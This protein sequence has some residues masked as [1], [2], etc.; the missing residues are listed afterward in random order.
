MS[1]NVRRPISQ[2]CLR[3]LPK[4]GEIKNSLH[5][6]LL[7]CSECDEEV[8]I[9]TDIIPNPSFGL[10]FDKAEFVGC[11]AAIDK[12]IEAILSEGARQGFEWSHCFK[13]K[14]S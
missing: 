4:I 11:D 5:K 7:T 6:E 12:T 10:P 3:F 13:V 1:C 8:V 14:E 2:D 9:H